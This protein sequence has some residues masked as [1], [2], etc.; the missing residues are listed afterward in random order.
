[1]I[2]ITEVQFKELLG[3][4]FEA[5]WYGSKDMKESVVEDLVSKTE[6]LVS[7][8]LSDLMHKRPLSDAADAAG[9][10]IVNTGEWV[11]NSF[12]IRVE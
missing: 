3:E 6:D 8:T 2:Y 12:D 11:V 5:G 10:F 4:A 7:K 1:M 9:N